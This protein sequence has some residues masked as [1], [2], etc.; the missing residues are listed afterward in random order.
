MSKDTAGDGG[1][2][3]FLKVNWCYFPRAKK[4]GGKYQPLK[5][6]WRIDRRAAVK[7]L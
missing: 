2:D 5:Y 3:P 1:R 4:D 7:W 6:R